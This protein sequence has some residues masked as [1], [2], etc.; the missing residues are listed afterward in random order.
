MDWEHAYVLGLAALATTLLALQKAPL[1]VV[2]L[3]LIVAVAAPG[4]ATSQQ[5]I[6]GF[7]N[8]AVVTIGAL[9]VVGEGFLRT[10][11]AAVL[12]SRIL[13]RTGH[14]ERSVTLSIVLLAAALSAFVNNIL[15]VVTLMPVVTSICRETGIYP[16][17]LLIPLSYAS[18]AG[19]LTTLVGTSTNLLVS[20]TLE[21]FGRP[22][23]SMFEISG[24]GIVLAV[25]AVLYVSLI[26][27]RMLPKIPS[28]ATQAGADELREYVTEI[29][30]GERSPLIGRTIASIGGAPGS[31]T[32][33]QMAIRDELPIPR[34]AF[35]RETIRARDLLVLRGRVQ[36]LA[37]LHHDRK[38]RD[39]TA[40]AN[41]EETERY[42]PSSMSFFELAIAPDSSLVG[43]RIAEIRLKERFGAVVV[44]ILR[45]GRHLQTRLHERR[46]NQGDLLLVFGNE[47]ARE[48]LRQSTDFSVIEGADRKIY[49]KDKAPTSLAIL[50]ALIAMFA[51]GVEPVT[52]A[53]IG[54]LAMVLTGCVTVR[55]AQNAVNWQ[56][57]IFIAGTIALSRALSATGADDMI[58]GHLARSL[59]SAGPF[60]LL[61]GIYVGTVA[62]TELLSNNAVAVLMTPVALA[63]AEAAGVDERILCMA[64][65]LAASNSFANPVG[66]KTNLVVFGPG[67]YRFRD[68][69]RVGIGLDLLLAAT[70]IAVL[71]LFFPL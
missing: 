30:I 9:Y 39:D 23:M 70:G 24:P 26:G 5:A 55:Q 40:S 12:A 64:V 44:G 8:K 37:S 51:G 60:V 17:R 4:L 43:K 69:V 47:A 25:V 11:S 20:G 13:A 22:P 14:D 27:R 33:V 28:L 45:A 36:D 41:G 42:D 68:F 7:G 62:L 19:G 49:R 38:H 56:I 10:G 16:S 65:A 53:L 6:H 71:P 66:Y 46:V 31:G 63:T 67:G 57:L 52:A 58:G 32:R 35:P 50:L 48:R 21:E 15:V 29:T 59:G 34:D 54:A 1:G 3:G 2:G 18:I 61:A